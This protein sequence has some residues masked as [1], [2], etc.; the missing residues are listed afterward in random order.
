MN[1]IFISY[2]HEDS[3]SDTGRIYAELTRYFG[4]ESVFLDQ[5]SI[6]SGE[7]FPE[8]LREAIDAAEVF[9]VVIGSSWLDAFNSRDATHSVDYVR[10][11]IVRALGRRKL[12][13][14]AKISV[15][16][17][18]LHH[19][20]LPVNMDDLPEEMREI[21]V[22]NAHSLRDGVADYEADVIALR[23]LIGS[24]C[25][26]LL[27]RRQNNWLMDS[28]K[29]K[30]QS[31]ADIG[32]DIAVLADPAQLVPRAH[33][34]EA[35]GNW[36]STWPEKRKP[37]V[38]LG[39]EGDGKSWA[40]SAWLAGKMQNGLGVPV[41]YTSAIRAAHSD[42]ESILADALDKSVPSFS[43]QGWKK[44]LSG[45]CNAEMEAV[46]RFILVLDGLNE[47]PSEEWGRS[48][49]QC[50]AS[51]WRE[52]LAVI[53]IC[54]S[55]YWNRRFEAFN[56][57]VELT[58]L[59]PYDDEELRDALHRAGRKPDDF[60]PDVLK[61]MAKP[62]SF[63]LA[64]RLYAE[65]EQ[66]GATLERLLLED[67]R[68][69]TR[70]KTSGQPM[71]HK[72]FLAWIR[73]LVR[74]EGDNLDRASFVSRSVGFGD[75][76]ELREEMLSAD[77]LREEDDGTFKIQQKPLLLG[78]GL[79]LA[80]E[81]KSC[82]EQGEA[83]MQEQIDRR[84]GEHPD[85]DLRVRV[86]GMALLY[87][88]SIKDFPEAGLLA[89]LRSWIEGRNFD[90]DDLNE[91]TAYLPLHPQTYLRMAEEVWGRTGNREVQDIFMRGFLRYRTHPKVREK[92]IESFTT[93]LGFIYLNGYRGYF[94][95]DVEKLAEA[96]RT[97]EGLLGESPAPGAVLNRFGYDLIATKNQGLMRLGQVAVA[98]I[99]HAT[100]RRPYC[101]ALVTG[102]IVNAAMEGGWPEFYWLCRT[103][104]NETQNELMQA[105]N[106]LIEQQQPLAYAA[107]R[108]VL[109]ALGSKAARSLC[110]TIPEQFRPEHEPAKFLRENRC[111]F[112]NWQTDNY[113]DCLQAQQWFPNQLAEKLQELAIQPKISLPAAVVAQLQEAG[114]GLALENVAAVMGN[115]RENLILEE[116][117]PALCAY[118][119]ERYAQMM[120]S[121][122]DE[123][124]V[125]DGLSRRMLAW[126][127]YDH[128]PVLDGAA[129]QA[130]ESA[131]N[132]TIEGENEENRWAELMLFS[133]VVFDRPAEE[134][135]H[136]ILQRP[137]HRGYLRGHEPCFRPFVS[138]QL[139]KLEQALDE[140]ESVRLLEA[141]Y[142]FQLAGALPQL[143][144]VL[145]SRL[146]MIFQEGD[147]N[148]RS[149]CLSIFFHA[150][151]ELAAR[152]VIES[153][154]QAPPNKEARSEAYYGSLLLACNGNAMSFDELAQRINPE[155]LGY[156][157]EKRGCK[158]YEVQAYASML[159]H[160][161][162]RIACIEISPE[163][164]GRIITVKIERNS[165][166]VFDRINVQTHEAGG[167]RLTNNTWGGSTGGSLERFKMAMDQE[168]MHEEL[169]QASRAVL[170]KIDAMRD[171]GNPFF[172]Q[173]FQHGN[174]DKVV[175]LSDALWRPWVDAAIE[176]GGKRIIAWC[177][178]FYEKLCA[179][180]LDHEPESGASLFRVL[181]T[182][183]TIQLND[184]DTRLSILL[185]DLFAAKS[186][187]SVAELRDS[188]LK[189]CTTDI[190]LFEVVMLSTLGGAEV[191]LNQ[192]IDTL[193]NSNWDYDRARAWMLEGY[194]LS[195]GVHERLLGFVESDGDSWVRDIAKISLQNQKRNTYAR[196]WFERFLV[197][198]N[199]VKAWAAFRLFLRC[200]DRRFWLWLPDMPLSEAE[201]WKRDALKANR[202]EICTMTEKNEKAWKNTLVGHEIK[203]DQMWP[204]M[205]SYAVEM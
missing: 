52:C 5:S 69:M 170:D 120:C 174:L 172:V 113:L 57:E 88:L 134:Q 110:E 44:V 196:H 1:E 144:T 62:R 42:I 83:A 70:H 72:E 158:S 106:A 96:R 190:A 130:I 19:A 46:P 153:G 142:Y 175:S 151:D 191:W 76:G 45:L 9:L 51:P 38:L 199:R 78:L 195:S 104:D 188:I 79:L 81:V 126:F 66:G 136:L 39:D 177:Q 68:D 27:A 123:L 135:L 167:A 63:K 176:V 165:E 12:E 182:Y 187:E 28:L 86:C 50:L 40:V 7:D 108:I 129:R 32:P 112:N 107:A 92:L 180:L 26:N 103:S 15:I 98:I 21:A 138:E 84:M 29:D 173:S 93:W 204:W 14:E 124:S 54:R 99:S 131:W 160:I 139:S 100:D 193:R 137:I 31:K 145:R 87:A 159:N 59:Q 192:Q 41:V 203:P 34:D 119:P 53:V 18:L 152:A 71:N 47:R 67:W 3:Y 20:K 200:V 22:L 163:L 114:A 186:S 35:L 30:N 133:C 48:L 185:I 122:A 111:E 95:R 154:W 198:N 16:P 109:R 205:K 24:H 168:A 197:E 73:E 80:H 6:Q 157:L 141:L 64:L 55:V 150:Q 179:T 33:V 102:M 94:E 132:A 101:R 178:A 105:A 116:I 58:T 183:D 4:S 161:W 121:L 43:E 171:A 91:I 201:L 85:M 2:R 77:I 8:K 149:A 17:V 147:S 127:L 97:V 169:S 189:D 164:G 75:P 36:W 118:L 202:A 25:G 115:T 146:L 13:C 89:L 11:E 162:Q 90:I 156:A 155:W 128:L 140:T 37:F 184:S 82:A 125:R 148:I 166:A 60:Y 65:V 61:V 181:R 49:Q 23:T 10:E 194:S 143:D 56:D 117:E 74:L